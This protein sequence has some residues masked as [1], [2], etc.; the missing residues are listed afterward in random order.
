MK[1]N[2]ERH[3]S[4]DEDGLGGLA[5]D[6]LLSGHRQEVAHLVPERVAGGGALGEVEH[7]GTVGGTG[8]EGVAGMLTENKV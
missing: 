7:T 8:R 2:N 6:L 3:T 4:V 1:T 5:V